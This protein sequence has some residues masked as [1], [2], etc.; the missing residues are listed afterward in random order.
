MNIDAHL[1][2]REYDDDAYNCAHFAVDAWKHLTGG[3]I[4]THME[5]FTRDRNSRSALSG[6][7]RLFAPLASPV[8]PCVAL[9][10]QPTAAPH[11]G[12]Y[13][14]D[15]VLHITRAGVLWQRP[16]IAA[17]GFTRVRYYKCL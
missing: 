3:D 13:W 2:D 6:L 17:L 16:E 15:K 12:M 8:S 7:R 10:H 1:L 14:R 9:Y 4:S 11:V 5:G